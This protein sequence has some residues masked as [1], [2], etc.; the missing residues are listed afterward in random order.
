MPIQNSSR[1]SNDPTEDILKTQSWAYRCTELKQ[2]KHFFCGECLFV[3]VVYCAVT[4]PLTLG[5][6]KRFFW[7]ISYREI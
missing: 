4:N 5:P 1:T 7:L 2:Q 3:A 6:L